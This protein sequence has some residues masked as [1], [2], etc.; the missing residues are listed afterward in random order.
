MDATPTQE[1][2]SHQP[3]AV[4][5]E[6]AAAILRAMEELSGDRDGGGEMLTWLTGAAIA[7]AAGVP[8]STTFVLLAR[9]RE[10]GQVR[11]RW[12]RIGTWALPVRG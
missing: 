12:G 10:A 2:V 5:D 4:S 7:S 8:T 6:R 1:A 11:R 3:S 9:L